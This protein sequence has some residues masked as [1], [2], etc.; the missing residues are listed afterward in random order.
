[1]PAL[2]SLSGNKRGFS[3]VEVLV[4]LG[5]IAILGAVAVPNLRNFSLNQEI[6]STA[7]QV[8]NIL[9]TAQSSAISRIK[10]PNGD[11]TETYIVR[12][13]SNN[14]SLVAKCD[15]SGDQIINIY[16]YAPQGSGNNNSFTGSIDVCPGLTTDIIFTKSQIT[17]LCFGSITPQTGN[18]KLTLRNSSGSLQKTVKIEPG[19]VIKV[20]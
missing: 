17:Y 11:T 6:E 20:E 8:A 1:M 18:V 15:L 14:Y 12:L 2:C 7:A 3:L 5:I 19:G 4:A 9:K 16:P 10:C 13:T